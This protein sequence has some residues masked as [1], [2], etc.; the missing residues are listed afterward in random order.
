MSKQSNDRKKDDHNDAGS[1]TSL[2]M[3]NRGGAFS[4]LT[5]YATE[6]MNYVKENFPA[7]HVLIFSFIPLSF[8]LG[9]KNSQSNVVKN[10]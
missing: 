8:N 9:N 3:E 5:G 7:L 4:G 1:H 6:R 10:K 2:E